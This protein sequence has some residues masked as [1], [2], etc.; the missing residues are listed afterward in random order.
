[1][2]RINLKW[3]CPIFLIIAGMMVIVLWQLP[4]LLPPSKRATVPIRDL[5]VDAAVFPT[6]WQVV[7]GPEPEPDGDELDW[8]EENLII[9]LE[10][11]NDR[12]FAYHRVMKFRNDVSALYGQI[13]IQRQ[14]L[15]LS[16][17]QGLTVTPAGW[18]YVSPIADDWRFACVDYGVVNGNAMWCTVLAR[19]DE[20]ISIFSTVMSPEHMTAKDLEDILRAIDDRFLQYLVP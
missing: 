8:G 1:V 9:S 20:Y 18:S 17:G 15:L 5:L 12:G 16:S 11:Q 14:G 7:R 6:D 3:G 2:K 4:T 19:Y 10:P 13:G